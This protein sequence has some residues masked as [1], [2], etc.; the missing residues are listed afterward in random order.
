M[1][2]L[3]CERIELGLRAAGVEVSMVRATPAGGF[4]HAAAG[5][6]LASI[7]VY[8]ED[9]CLA[10]LVFAGTGEVVSPEDDSEKFF[11]PGPGI[12]GAVLEVL[13]GSGRR[14]DQE[15]Q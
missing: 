13:V 14:E 10:V 7:D 11:S 2:V 5:D 12:A 8:Y 15:S 4:L 1:I 6:R 3:T 9:D